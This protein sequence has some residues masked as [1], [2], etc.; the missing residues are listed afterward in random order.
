MAVW[1]RASKHDTAPGIGVWERIKTHIPSSPSAPARGH[2]RASGVPAGVA[3]DIDDVV[4]R[5]R[6]VEPEDVLVLQGAE[7]PPRHRTSTARRTARRRARRVAAAVTTVVAM[8]LGATGAM[9]AAAVVVG[10][11]TILGDTFEQ[12][13]NF[14]PD[15]SGKIDWTSGTVNAFVVDDA[16]IPS[17]GNLW[18]SAFQGSSKEEDP[19]KWTCQAKEGGVTPGKDNLLR[20]Y[21]SAR[22]TT[23]AAFLDLGLVKQEGEGDTHVNF[24][25][26]KLGQAVGEPLN[27]SCPITRSVGDFLVAYDFGG[28]SFLTAEVRLFTWGANNKWNELLT[29]FSAVAANNQVA[30]ADDPMVA[31]VQPLEA[32]TFAEVTIKLPD[33]F[34][35]CPGFAYANVRSRSSHSI[36][37]ALQD[38]MPTTPVDVSTCGSI[39]LQKNDDLGAPLAGATFGLYTNAQATGA[40][41][42]TCVTN[43]Q[44]VCTMSQVAPGSYWIK[45]ISSPSTHNPDPDIVP[46]TVTFRAQSTVT[47]PFVNPLI[48]GSLQ[49]T[50][51]HSL[52]GSVAGVRFFLLQ[53]GVAATNRDGAAA[54]CTTAANGTCTINRLVPGTYTV[55]EDASTVPST[56]TAVADQTVTI[57]GNQTAQVSFVNPVK[58]IAIDL[59]KTVNDLKSITVHQGDTYTYKLSIKNTGQL[60]LTLTSLTDAANGSPVSLPAGCTGLIGDVLAAGA[61][62]SCTYTGTG[63]VD[64]TN[65]ANVVG[66]DVFGRTASDSDNAA[67]DVINP[68]IELTKTVNGEESVTLHE[69]DATTY[70]ITFENTGDTPL[71]ITSL[72]DVAGGTPLTLPATCAALVSSTP[73][74]PSATRSCTYAST[75]PAGG[76]ANTATV[77][78]VDS[79]G[80]TKGTVTASDTAVVQVIDPSI[81]LTK[82]VNGGESDIVHQGDDLVYEITFTNNG[83]TPL[84]ITS[85]TD[86]A[87]GSTVDLPAGCENLVNSTPLAVGASRSCTYSA[88]AGSADVTNT[89]TVNGEDSLGE[90]VS[91]SDSA[92][93]DVIHPVISIVKK[94]NGEDSVTAHEGDTVTY[95]LL[96][97]NTGDTALTISALTDVA[98][99]KSVT[100]STACLDLVGDLLAVGASV[101]CTYTGTAPADDV[102]NTATV[103]G[104]DSIGGEKGTVQASDSALVDVIHPAI[105]LTKLVNGEESVTVHADDL[106]T[107][108]VT[109]TN[110]GDT[111]LEVTSFVDVANG[112]GVDLPTTCDAFVGQILQPTE[113]RTCVYTATA[114]AADVHN[115]ATVVGEDAIGGDKGTVDATDEAWVTVIDP[116]IQIVKTVNGEDEITVH[117]G[118]ALTYDLVITNIGDTPLTITSLVDKA[119]GSNMA[120]SDDCAGLVGE[121]LAVGA[122][123]DCSYD[124][125]ATELDVH[126]VAT[127]V[128]R[129]ELGGEDDDEDDA[130]VAVLSPAIDIVKT[131]NG[132]ESTTVHVGDALT[133]ELV[134]TNTGDTELTLTSLTDVANGANVD[135]PSSCDGLVGDRLAIDASVGCTYSTVATAADVT[136]V[137]TVVGVDDLGGEKGTVDDDDDASVD[138]LNPAIQIVKTVNGEDST[139]VHEGDALTYRLVITNTGDAPLTITSLDDVANDIDVTLPED[140][141]S[142]VGTTLAVRG[143]VECEYTTTATADDV[144]NVATVVGEDELGGEKGTVDDDDDAHV[145]VLNPAVQIV[146]TVNGE[147][148]V[149]VHAGDELVYE[150]VITNTG[151]ATLT[152]TD[153]DDEANDAAVALPAECT[154]LVGTDLAPGASAS[155]SYE[156]V[157][158]AADVTNVATVTGEDELGKEVDD[159]DDAQVDVINPAIRIVKTVNGADSV[160]VHAGDELTYKLVITNTGDTALTLSALADV[161][162][163]AAV[164]LPTGCASLVDTV[165]AV[166]ASVECSYTTVATTQDVTNVATT[167][168][169]DELGKEV[170]DDD[171][172]KVDVLNP[173]IQVV[174]TANP[175]EIQGTSGTATFTYVVTNIGDT[176]L[177]GVAV[178]DDILGEIGRIDRLEVGESK[179]LTKTAPVS[180]AAPVNVATATGKDELGKTV[181]DDDD[182]SITFVAGVVVERP[183]PPA[184]AP[185]AAPLPRTG[186]G[187]AT[188][189]AVGLMLIV[190]G[191]VAIVPNRRRTLLGSA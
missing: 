110:T 38:K 140:C 103:T 95:S 130:H 105:S 4:S 87:N 186:A 85:L 25:F 150:L 116:E 171:D 101:S 81:T 100:L 169:E 39:V 182:A 24:E 132:E 106:L 21:I 128:G 46:V 29:G 178:S 18:D 131:V 141:S 86:V 174:K 43:A 27:G 143:S 76:V 66:T 98:G 1:S 156:T 19:A 65:I 51:T 9:P 107:Y 172:A 61:T 90:P 35:S 30:I 54:E 93:V 127:V 136:N 77:I 84:T 83:D 8:T 159:D 94:V 191:G 113:S 102:T 63:S 78:G 160:K 82:T 149:T 44:G 36:D 153:L 177:L 31:G 114:T 148:A 111:P 3:V 181:T 138:V 5:L 71:T 48:L 13:G 7:L 6:P 119:N 139:T 33:S 45:E 155:C 134:I 56:M 11:G 154:E 22:F 187:L 109:F 23:S 124:A 146:K 70:V 162:N 125:T 137:A 57:V 145:D 17:G 144:H 15:G 188:Q 173:A 168:G 121:V 161:A 147:D 135:L 120:L 91:A 41:V 32:R 28:T 14:T 72:A 115:V 12:D 133:Y 183:A 126:N 108:M 68:G 52:G 104:V 50:K 40:T 75:A 37:S 165:L 60:P 53:N 2:D 79:L 10:P 74:A 80:G 152:L 189:V 123:V 73:L 88:K 166:G 176:T 59:V 34:L 67:V 142:L 47:L 170:D 89:A 55:R 96:V 49:I 158:T 69:G 97:T 62:T 92:V 190:I 175:T 16:L 112:S 163:G 167:S 99:G 26:N 184:P 64:V 117:E 118:D 179:T 164:T 185:A 129:D 42:A 122:S 151:D 58:P 157:A 180:Q 20:A